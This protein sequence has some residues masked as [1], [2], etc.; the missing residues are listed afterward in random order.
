M[1]TQPTI[2]ET[3][4]G[5]KEECLSKKR[6]DAF[7][8]ILSIVGM[9][10]LGFYLCGTFKE[11][12]LKTPEAIIFCGILLLNSGL[13]N[14][15]QKLEFNDK[16]II[17]ELQ[18]SVLEVETTQKALNKK[19]EKLDRSVEEILSFLSQHLLTHFERVH[20]DRLSGEKPYPCNVSGG[21]ENELRRLRHLGFIEPKENAALKIAELR[22]SHND[23]RER[24]KVTERGR[25]YLEIA[26][27]L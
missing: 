12:S 15:I 16:G 11:H 8:L 27:N 23:L 25:T 4:T 24:L 21:C 5:Q 20:L 26:Q 10:Y 2:A 9:A 13:V 17:F 19:Q 18:K 3:E 7:R 22:G 1:E 14:R 6:F